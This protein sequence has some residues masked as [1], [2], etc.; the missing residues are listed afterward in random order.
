M[1]RSVTVLPVLWGIAPQARYRP[2]P[3]RVHERTVWRGWA[4][5]ASPSGHD[6]PSIHRRIG[7]QTVTGRTARQRR[8]WAVPPCCSSTML[9]RW[10]GRATHRRTSLPRS[11][12]RDRTRVQATMVPRRGGACQADAGAV[13]PF[14]ALRPA[15]IGSA[16]LPWDG[17]APA[18][19]RGASTGRSEDRCYACWRHAFRR[20]LCGVKLS[21][22]EPARGRSW[23]RGGLRPLL[24]G[25]VC[26]L[27]R[28]LEG[29]D[30]GVAGH[31]SAGHFVDLGAL[32]L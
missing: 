20:E 1:Q 9:A 7:R 25:Q 15:R 4:R 12:V 18:L 11:V 17:P 32:G 21:P 10:S 24:G 29:F 5:T 3:W 22:H 23:G 30:V 27:D 8:S 19:A 31:G 14:G 2:S 26:F 13:P 16:V 28:G 6:P